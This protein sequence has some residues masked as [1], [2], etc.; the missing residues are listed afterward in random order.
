MDNGMLAWKREAFRAYVVTKDLAMPM[1][2]RDSGI[3][4]EESV[5]VDYGSTDEVTKF[6]DVGHGLDNGAWQMTCNC[7]KIHLIPVKNAT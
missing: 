5:L 7:G 4:G 1:E 3:N 6:D 2:V